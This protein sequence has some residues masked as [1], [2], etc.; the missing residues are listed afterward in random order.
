MACSCSGSRPEARACLDGGA[1]NGVCLE[2]FRAF[3]REHAG[4][5]GSRPVHSTLHGSDRAA[6]HARRLPIRKPGGANQHHR[7]AVLRVELRQ[8][9]AKL[10]VFKVR[11]LLRVFRLHVGKGRECPGTPAVTPPFRIKVIAHDGAQPRV[12]TRA[13][14]E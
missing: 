6:A 14:L 8:R 1:E 7:L 11:Y 4:K 2:V 10:A 12:H 13:W 3:H 9:R 5:L